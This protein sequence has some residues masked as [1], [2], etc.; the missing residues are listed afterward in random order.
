MK[1]R[2]TF[3]NSEAVKNLLGYFPLTPEPLYHY[4]TRDAAESMTEGRIRLTRADC[5][6]DK[7]E[8]E[9]GLDLLSDAIDPA[10]P[11]VEIPAALRERLG[12]CYVLSLTSDP[13]NIYLAKEHCGEA[14]PSVLRFKNPH[15][16]F[17]GAW[18]STAQGDG[19]RTSHFD[20]LYDVY[21]GTVIYDPDMQQEIVKVLVDSLP[22]AANPATHP[23]DRMHF[24]SALIVLP[25]LLFKRPRYA[26]EKESR[27]VVVKKWD[28]VQSFEQRSE[29]KD[30][31]PLVYIEANLAGKAAPIII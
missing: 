14:P 3:T 6:V 11:F 13:K 23:S 12:Q 9:Y 15:F 8:I 1:H 22:E 7:S 10:G 4:T 16:W 5:L 24:V 21:E 26:E 28:T 29:R 2:V 19:F 31:S 17:L 27:I 30:G 20:G 25:F 18:H